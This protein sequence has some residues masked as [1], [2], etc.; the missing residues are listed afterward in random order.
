MKH[1]PLGPLNYEFS[2][3][4]IFIQITP[5]LSIAPNTDFEGGGGLGM[6]FFF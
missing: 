3:L 5:R 2:R 1:L 4:D 6:R